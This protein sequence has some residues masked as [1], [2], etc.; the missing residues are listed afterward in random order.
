[1]AYWKQ[2]DDMLKKMFALSD[3]GAKSLKGGIIAAA[4]YNLCLMIP[5]GL[6]MKLV[7]DMLFSIES[8]EPVIQKNIV[9][10]LIGAVVLFALIFAAQWVQYNKTYTTA[11]EESANR[12]IVL[13]EKM[14]KLPLS[15][16]GKKD[17]ADLTT[18][19]MGD[20]T[21]L[22]RTFS[23]ANAVW[24]NCDLYFNI[25]WINCDRLSYGTMHSI[26]CSVGNPGAFSCQK[27][28]AEGRGG[29]CAGKKKCL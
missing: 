6:L 3:K 1:M 24:N 21:A 5:V 8:G 27:S 12:R 9:F 4:F 11:Y 10:Y 2:G 20:C 22:E 14:R 7:Q 16:F 19:I 23:N 17:I 13:A 18:T 15:F 26:T 28:T 29:E 25:N